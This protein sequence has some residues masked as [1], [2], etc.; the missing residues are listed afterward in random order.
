TGA[1][2]VVAASLVVRAVGYRGVAVRGL[3]FDDIAGHIP[4]EQGRIVGRE[5]EY[6]VGWIKRGPTGVI[7][8]NK[9]DARET[10]ERLLAD[11]A[12]QGPRDLGAGRPERLEQWL[13]HKQP[14]LVGQAGWQAID[15]FERQAGQHHGRPRIKLVRTKDLLAAG[16]GHDDR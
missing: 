3:P 12:G 7:G 1:R 9:K 15:K 6:V 13:L 2:E 8:T 16:R 5:R 10:V 11:L 14:D 4:H